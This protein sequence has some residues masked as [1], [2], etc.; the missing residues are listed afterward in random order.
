MGISK[1]ETRR[2]ALTL[3]CGRGVPPGGWAVHPSPRAEEAR[4]VQPLAICGAE[5]IPRAGRS[6]REGT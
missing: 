4:E 1:H 2:L 6:E 5:T 3:R